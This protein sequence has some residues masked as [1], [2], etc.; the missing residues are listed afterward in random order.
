MKQSPQ[1]KKAQE[2]MQ[3]GVMSLE[4]FLGPDHRDLG[5]I[6]DEDDIAV[7]D[8]G[9]THR[10]IADR[11]RRLKEKGEAGLGEFIR[12]EPNLDVQVNSVRGG[13]P[14]PFGDKGLVPKTNIT[15]FN[16]KTGEEVTFT[17]LSIHFIEKHRFYQGQGS[18]FRLVP[19]KL[20]RVI[21]LLAPEG[22]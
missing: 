9:L 14:C 12:V 19:E 15:V 8:L 17:D 13:L 6:I 4:G 5:Q 21:G 7:R 3:A 18:R 22:K 10:Q 16:L 11:M 1:L 20:A 2:N